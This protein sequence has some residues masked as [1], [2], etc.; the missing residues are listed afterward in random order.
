[1]LEVC[2]NGHTRTEANTRWHKR[3]RGDQVKRVCL[4]CKSL[5]Y[6]FIHPSAAQIQAQLT[7]ERHEDVEDLLP[8][9]ATLGEVVARSGYSTLKRLKASLKRRERTD[10]LEQLA[11]KL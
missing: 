3:G 5:R 7:T 1:M 10:L 6:E 11:G 8:L 9:G 2:I 4:D